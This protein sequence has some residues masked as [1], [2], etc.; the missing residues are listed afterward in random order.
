MYN[1]W[2][3]FILSNIVKNRY[4]SSRSWN[5]MEPVLEWWTTRV[6]VRDLFYISSIILY[7][8]CSIVFN[9]TTIQ[10]DYTVYISIDQI[11]YPL[12]E[13]YYGHNYDKLINIYRLLEMC[14]RIQYTERTFSC[15]R[16]LKTYFRNTIATVR[17]NYHNFLVNFIFRPDWHCRKNRTGQ[18]EVR[19]TWFLDIIWPRSAKSS[20]IDII[21]LT[22][23]FVCFN[24][25]IYSINF[26]L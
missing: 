19:S 15:L 9:S 17:I 16:T 26:N 14:I 11:S 6:H 13:M 12:F 2:T 25:F 20:E 22:N 8:F 5:N 7:L 4:C 23:T 3:V 10:N 18:R 21:L 24:T 1:P